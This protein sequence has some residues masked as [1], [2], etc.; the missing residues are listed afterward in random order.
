MPYIFSIRINNARIQ[1]AFRLVFSCVS[2]SLAFGFVLL[3]KHYQNVAIIV[4]LEMN[5]LC[6]TYIEKGI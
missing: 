4:I 3:S 5:F 2:E 1:L 6:L